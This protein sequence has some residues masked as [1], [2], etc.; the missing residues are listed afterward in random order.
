[1]K[2]LILFVFGAT[3]LFNLSCSRDDDSNSNFT[4]NS[5]IGKWGVVSSTF[6]GTAKNVSTGQTVTLNNKTVNASSCIAQSYELYNSDGTN[7]S[8]L[9]S[10]QSGSCAKVSETTVHYTYNSSNHVITNTDDNVSVELYKL[11]NTELGY[12]YNLTNQDMGNG[13]TFTGTMFLNLVKK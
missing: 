11:T 9:Y 3:L 5:I 13:L 4:S 12:K 6:N 2:K 10:D 7:Y 1:M 8:I